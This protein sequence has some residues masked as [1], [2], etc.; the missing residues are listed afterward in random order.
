MKMIGLLVGKGKLLGY[1]VTKLL[2]KGALALRYGCRDKG[3]QWAG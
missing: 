2:R 1:G 3:G